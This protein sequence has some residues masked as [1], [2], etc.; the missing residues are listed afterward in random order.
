MVWLPLVG[1]SVVSLLLRICSRLLWKPYVLSVLSSRMFC[2]CISSIFREF[3]GICGCDCDVVVISRM[4][5]RMVRPFKNANAPATIFS[6][7]M[8]V[9][10]QFSE[11][12][13]GP[14]HIHALFMQYCTYSMDPISNY[15]THLCAAKNFSLLSNFMRLIVILFAEEVNFLFWLIH[16]Y[17]WYM[18]LKMF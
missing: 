2:L 4:V 1:T 7:R 9:F 11:L 15:C 16:L 3:A 8:N 5:F 10:S 14:G 17:I 6:G 18:T 13:C 12:N